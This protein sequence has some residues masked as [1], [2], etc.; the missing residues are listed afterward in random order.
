MKWLIRFYTVYF[1]IYFTL[2]PSFAAAKAFK[3]F[4]TP[5]NHKV[6][7]WETAIINQSEQNM[8]SIAGYN[9]ATYKWGNGEK[10]ALLVHGWEGNGGSLG[11]IGNL[12]LRKG[13]TVYS[14]DGPAHGKSSGKQ[15]N[16][17]AFSAVVAELLR[18]YE[19]KDLLVT[20][21]FGSATSTYALADN[22]DLK[23]Q[24]MIMLTSPNLLRNVLKEFAAIL[25]LRTKDMEHIKKYI[26]KKYQ[27]SAD[28]VNVEDYISKATVDSIIIL[29]DVEDRI[30]PFAYSEAIA[31]KNKKVQLV[32]LTGT[33]HYKMLWDD[34]VL[35]IIEKMVG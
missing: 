10:K 31:A 8:L 16:V 13:Y 18:K 9:I 32:P 4:S 3:I 17:M 19:I 12:L 11:A 21:S 20:H 34:K 5:L 29:H 1:R 25:K 23:M 27:R 15:T 6:R 14:F 7:D 2:M 28:S 33:G 30:I 35:G 26:F 22:T 24:Q